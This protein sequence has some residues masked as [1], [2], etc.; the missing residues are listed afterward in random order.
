EKIIV[1]GNSTGVPRLGVPDAGH[2][3]GLHGL[4]QRPLGG[5]G[6]RKTIQTTQFAQVAGMGQTWDPDLI[7]KAGET[8]GGE[9]RR[10]YNHRDKSNEAP[11]PLIVWGPNADLARD[12]RWGRIDESYGEDPFFTGT[13]TAALVKGMQGEDPKYWRVASLMKH[14]LANSNE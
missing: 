10:I 11:P 9:A 14:F 4:V 8:Q 7:R 2:S 1:L 12:P 6:N 5:L 3:E 13:M